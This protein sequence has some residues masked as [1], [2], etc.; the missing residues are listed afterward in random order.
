MSAQRKI[1]RTA[2]AAFALLLAGSAGAAGM[3]VGQVTAVDPARNTI[4]IN[5]V[6]F[7]PTD[8]SRRVLLTRINEIKPGAAVL[9]E[10]NG[11]QLIRI[12]PVRGGADFPAF[13]PPGPDGRTGPAKR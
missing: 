7:E 1:F 11:K 6:T 12:E 5:G 4:A 10:T 9:F 8:A 2:L 13:G 3:V